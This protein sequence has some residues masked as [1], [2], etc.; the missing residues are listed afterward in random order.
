MKWHSFPAV[1]WALF[2]IQGPRSYVMTSGS[3]SYSVSW[4]CKK[5]KAGELADYTVW[6]YFYLFFS[7]SVKKASKARKDLQSIHEGNGATLPPHSA[8]NPPPPPFFSA[9][10][11]TSAQV[12]QHAPSA[13]SCIPLL[14][15]ELHFL[16]VFVFIYV[17]VFIAS[18]AQAHI[19]YYLR[20]GG[21]VLFIQ[22]CL[23]VF[24][25]NVRRQRWTFVVLPVVPYCVSPV[26]VYP[27][28]ARVDGFAFSCSSSIFLPKPFTFSL[29]EPFSLHLSWILPTWPRQQCLEKLFGFIS[30]MLLVKSP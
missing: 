10:V 6:V 24:L 9:V 15:P 7:L 3:S 30:C 20:G 12:Q 2:R 17:Y 1:R 5:K 19:L 28:T 8:R 23:F 18:C 11:L 26:R 22:L 13:L 14:L 27:E 25:P 21:G 16:S 29:K 4:L